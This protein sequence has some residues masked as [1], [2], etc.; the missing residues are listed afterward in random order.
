MRRFSSQDPHRRFSISHHDSQSTCS[1]TVA[2]R[3]PT[4]LLCRSRAGLSTC[5]TTSTTSTSRPSRREPGAAPAP[6]SPEQGQHRPARD[7]GRAPT[8]APTGVPGLRHGLGADGTSVWKG[9]AAT[10]LPP[11][12]PITP[13]PFALPSIQPLPSCGVLSDL[14]ALAK[15]RLTRIV[16][17]KG[18]AP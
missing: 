10:L 9:V 17:W 11:L 6:V 13:R 7:L 15:H 3:R 18:V 16:T 8:S 1:S 14:V 4:R 2:W 5:S 12:P